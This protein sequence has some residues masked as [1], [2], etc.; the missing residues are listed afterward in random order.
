MTV[1]AESIVENV[2][3]QWGAW[4]LA[5]GLLA[6][7]G[8]FVHHAFRTQDRRIDRLESALKQRDEVIA[9]KDAQILA[10]NSQLA[11]LHMRSIR[12]WQEAVAVFRNRKC[13]ADSDLTREGEHAR[14]S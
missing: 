8:V 3:L 9:E 4:A 13:L 1:L 7:L 14:P 12:L 6:A 10:M 5:V 11:D 2:P